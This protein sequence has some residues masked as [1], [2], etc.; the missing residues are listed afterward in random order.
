[1]NP[2]LGVVGFIFKESASTL[3]TQEASEKYEWNVIEIARNLEVPWDLALSPHGNIFIT[4]REGRVKLLQKSGQIKVIST[5]PQVVSI[6]ESGLTGIALHPQFSINGQLYLYY[7]YT[8]SGETLNKVSRFTFK[9]NRLEEER[10]IVDNLPG[11][12]IH[13][14]GRLKFGPDGKL[15]IL[16]GDGGQS[17]LAQSIRFLGGKVLRVNDDGSIPEDNPIRGSAVYSL[18]HRNPQGLDWQPPSLQD[19]ED[20]Y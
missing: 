20:R 11:G 17:S 9:N 7:T 2:F 4:E 5:L 19:Y 14:G 13:N 18:G 15:W 6:N 3:T 16:V 8:S 12:N 10:V 1:M